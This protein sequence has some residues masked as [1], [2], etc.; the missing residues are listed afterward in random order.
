MK[1]LFFLLLIFSCKTQEQIQREQMVDNMAVQMQQGQKLSAE[2]TV[3]LQNLEEKLTQKIGSLEEIQHGH[4]EKSS[5]D[6]ELNKTNM[7]QLRLE[8][9]EQ[10]KTLLLI[11]DQ[12]DQQKKYLKKLLSSLNK[13]AGEKPKKKKKSSYDQAMY[14]YKKGHYKRA[15]DALLKLLNN[16]R[17]KGNKKARVI[18]NLGMIAFMDKKYSDAVTLFSRLYTK[19][20][21]SPYTPRGLLFLGKSFKKINRQDE[22]KQVLQELVKNYPKSKYNKKAKQL[23]K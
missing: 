9:K 8:L 18:H 3:R 22:A 20:P 15:Q 16:K 4:G 14:L 23:L 19:Y 12:M 13:M 1:I 2:Y 5:K 21:K 10:K 6:I 7:S 17:I 11:S